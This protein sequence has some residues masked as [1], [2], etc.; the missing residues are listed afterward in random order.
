MN[1]KILINKLKWYYFDYKN[2]YPHYNE[3]L[4]LMNK[5]PNRISSYS[6][7]IKYYDLYTETKDI[8]STADILLVTRERV[9]QCLRT[10]KRK[11][12]E[13]CEK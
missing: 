10:I 13:P 3:L 12:K 6:G 7:L 4:Y 1:L 5:N 2:D 11:L 8:S 9:R